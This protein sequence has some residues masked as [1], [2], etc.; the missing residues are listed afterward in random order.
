MKLVFLKKLCLVKTI[1]KC[2]F[3]KTECLTNTYKSDDLSGKLPK[4]TKCVCMC[5]YIYKG[6]YFIL[7]IKFF[8]II[9]II[10][11]IIITSC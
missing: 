2:F 11:I 6:V 10:I 9:I 3:F 8:L 4:M 5:V 1:K 7:S